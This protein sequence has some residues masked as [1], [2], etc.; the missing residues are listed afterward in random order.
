MHVLSVMLENMLKI[1]HVVF[2]GPGIEVFINAPSQ[3]KDIQADRK[4]IW[5]TFPEQYAEL[6]HRQFEVCPFP[7][8]HLT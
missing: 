8:D 2:N 6:P 3:M 7:E 5:E 1:S 4:K